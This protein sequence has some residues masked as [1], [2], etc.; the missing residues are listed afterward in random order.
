MPTADSTAM[1]R[2]LDVM[3]RELSQIRAAN[4]PNDN[5]RGKEQE[6]AMK[7]WNKFQKKKYE[8]NQKLGELRESVDKLTDMKHTLGDSKPT[9]DIIKLRNNNDKLMKEIGPLFHELKQLAIIEDQKQQKG[10]SKMTEKEVNDMKS[11]TANLGKEIVELGNRNARSNINVPGARTGNDL[12]DVSA[13]IGGAKKAKKQKE[14]KS[15]RNRRRGKQEEYTNDVEMS[16]APMSQQA[17]AFMDYKDQEINQQNAILEEISKAT[18][19]LYEISVDMGKTLTLQ[20]QI[21]DGIEVKMERNI[22]AIKTQNQK[23]KTILEE[24]GGMTRF[25]PMMICTIIL[26]AC[27]GYIYAIM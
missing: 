21:I 16:G 26:L 6:A 7:G 15:R 11:V 22:Q 18:E 10:K 8:L 2:K 24:S 14:R 20:N 13:Q 3:L 17:Q 25:C 4:F 9:A 19:E 27:A 1:L 5:G 12:E 23:L